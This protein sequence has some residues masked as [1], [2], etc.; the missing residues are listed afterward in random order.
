MEDATET[1]Q[2]SDLA[3]TDPVATG[4][5]TG[6]LEILSF[7][8]HSRP[9]V[10]EN[11]IAYLPC[12]SSLD[13]SLRSTSGLRASTSSGP[14]RGVFPARGPSVSLRGLPVVPTDARATPTA[15]CVAFHPLSAADSQQRFGLVE[16]L[17]LRVHHEE[18]VVSGCARD[19]DRGL[20]PRRRGSYS[21]LVYM[22]STVWL[23]GTEV[24]ARPCG[25]ASFECDISD[26]ATFGGENV[27]AGRVNNEQPSSRWYSGSGIYRHV[28]LKTVDPV[29]VAYTGTHVTTPQ[30]SAG[31]ATA[32]V[33]VEVQN[34]A[35]SVH[36]ARAATAE[37]TVLGALAG[38]MAR[39]ATST[40][41]RPEGR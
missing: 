34:D 12:Q 5:L 25:Y 26:R 31:S 14:W 33:S 10:V 9:V 3:F 1:L 23:N 37:R 17:S 27:L 21:L 11:G 30:T 29:H 38:T 36:R 13:P 41:R 15:R 35:G 4:D 6:S 16:R 40:R 22:D 18:V 2:E 24:C 32:S 7:R 8:T 19:G 39:V 28:W 20:H